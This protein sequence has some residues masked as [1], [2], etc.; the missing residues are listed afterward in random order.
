MSVWSSMQIETIHSKQTPGVSSQAYG[1]TGTDKSDALTPLLGSFN[2]C[3]V[4]SQRLIE[5]QVFKALHCLTMPQAAA[6]STPHAHACQLC[7]GHPFSM[8]ISNASYLLED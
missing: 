6:I 3:Q 1:A 7:H 4:V 5:R 8:R 2:R